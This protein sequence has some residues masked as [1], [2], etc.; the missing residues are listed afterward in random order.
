MQILTAR[1]CEA[2]G[3]RVRNGFRVKAGSR[4]SP[5]VAESF[6]MQRIQYGERLFL[7]A[8][9]IVR[10]DVFSRDYTFI[11]AAYAASVISGMHGREKMWK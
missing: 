6:K 3:R 5:D 2:V 10:D 9:G 7:I 11:S 8:E 4:I 1:G